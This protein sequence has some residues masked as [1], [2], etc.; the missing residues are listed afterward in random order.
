M[1]RHRKERQALDQRR[2]PRRRSAIRKRGEDTL[3]PGVLSEQ[4]EGP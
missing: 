2:V 1:P 3:M 4:E